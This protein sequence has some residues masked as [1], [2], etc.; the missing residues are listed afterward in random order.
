MTKQIQYWHD[1]ELKY[2]KN[3]WPIERFQD[4]VRSALCSVALRR[5]FGQ[6]MESYYKQH[7]EELE[8]QTYM[9]TLIEC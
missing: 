9:K 7:P 8:L 5:D 2:K 6:S 4:R 1:L 3:G